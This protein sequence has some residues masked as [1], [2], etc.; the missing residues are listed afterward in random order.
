MQ[1]SAL[2]SSRSQG[3]ARTEELRNA[4]RF[5]GAIARL[6]DVRTVPKSIEKTVG[7]HRKPQFYC[8]VHWYVCMFMYICSWLNVSPNHA[9][10][11]GVQVLFG[12]DATDLAGS[13]PPEVRRPF[14][15][16]IFQF[17][18]HKERNKAQLLFATDQKCKKWVENF[19]TID[20]RMTMLQWYTHSPIHQIIFCWSPCRSTWTVSCCA[21]SCKKPKRSLRQQ[22][23]RGQD[24]SN[25]FSYVTSMSQVVMILVY[26]VPVMCQVI[27]SLVQGQGGTPAEVCARRPKDT[28]QAQEMGLEAVSSSRTRVTFCVTIW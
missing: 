15:R 22:E 9:L 16:I 18:Q 11:A 20:Y 13:L 6:F 1:R 3:S 27:V 2:G 28:W 23:R 25:V 5:H 12:V 4:G 7:K 19:K 26:H 14:D 17:P 10:H 24:W 21:N 8:R